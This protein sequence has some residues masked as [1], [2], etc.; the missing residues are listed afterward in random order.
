MCQ[1]SLRSNYW[2]RSHLRPGNCGPS[3]VTCPQCHCHQEMLP[4]TSQEKEEKITQQEHGAWHMVAA[5][6]SQWE[7]LAT[8]PPIRCQ[9]FSVVFSPHF[10]SC[11]P[12]Q[13]PPSPPLFH[14][15]SH[16]TGLQLHPCSPQ[17]ISHSVTEAGWWRWRCCSW[18]RHAQNGRGIHFCFKK[19]F[20]YLIF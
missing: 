14:L 11:L 2:M 13:T 5:T 4:S 10:Y 20:Y 17:F 16:N 8:L 18:R 19:H 1:T 15:Y 12:N 3:P 7:V 9:V 6:S